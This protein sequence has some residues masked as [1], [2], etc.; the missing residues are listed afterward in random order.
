MP[1]M[2]GRETD[3]LPDIHGEKKWNSNQNSMMSVSR[4]PY[5]A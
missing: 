3:E 2:N 5:V 1:M 4:K